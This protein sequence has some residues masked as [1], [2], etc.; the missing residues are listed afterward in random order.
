MVKPCYNKRTL[1]SPRY[2]KWHNPIWI[3]EAVCH[4]QI[5][6]F[7][8]DIVVFEDGP[9]DADGTQPLPT[10]QLSCNFAQSAIVEYH[11]PTCSR[12]NNILNS[13]IIPRTSHSSGFTQ[14]C[15]YVFIKNRMHNTYKG[16]NKPPSTSQTAVKA[17]IQHLVSAKVVACLYA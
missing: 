17:F 13:S 9:P 12:N 1:E 5:V 11:N 3:I 7:R 14:P 2:D 16:N 15:N 6:T 10:L 8:Y 4:Q